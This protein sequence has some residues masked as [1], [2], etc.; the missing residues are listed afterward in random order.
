MT[1]KTLTPNTSFKAKEDKIIEEAVRLSS[2]W[3]NRYIEEHTYEFKRFTSEV[4][5]CLAIARYEWLLSTTRKAVLDRFSDAE[6]YEIATT[7][8]YELAIPNDYSIARAV[9]DDNEVLWKNYPQTRFA[10]LI[11]KLLAL[12]PL[13]DMVVRDLVE[14]FWHGIHCQ[15][16]HFSDYI[17][18][19]RENLQTVAHL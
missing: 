17:K 1:S 18:E 7:L 10:S 5:I 9:A 6:L 15:V 4:T 8:Q 19:V 16:R 13:E 2:D 14:Q 12:T 3:H 11:E